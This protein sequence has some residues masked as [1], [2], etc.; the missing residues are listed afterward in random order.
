MEK[1][2]TA[3]ICCL[4]S[5]SL[6]ATDFEQFNGALMLA[7]TKTDNKTYICSSVAHS[8]TKLLTAAHCL[9]NAVEVKV[10]TEGD[11]GEEEKDIFYQTERFENNPR[12]DRDK[13]L[14]L[15]DI[16]V[17]ELT[18]PL[19]TTIKTYPILELDDKETTLLRI[20]FGMR[21]GIND[22]TLITNI[23]VQN[24][25][26]DFFEALDAFSVSGDSGGPIF[27]KVGKQLYIVG[28]HSTVESETTY[29]TR[30]TPEISDWIESY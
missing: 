3:I 2:F 10:Y 30:F 26:G 21:D 19:P 7:I 16:G 27:K 18:T 1:L 17:I 28:I 25:E 6:F 22:R 9:K 4:F 23:S 20:G 14:Y 12:Y 11:S 5:Q 8:R 29:N 13:S 24:I 15:Y